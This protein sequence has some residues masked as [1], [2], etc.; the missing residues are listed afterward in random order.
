MTCLILLNQINWMKY[1]PRRGGVILLDVIGKRLGFGIDAPTG[2]ITDFGGSIKRR[3]HPCEGSLREFK[4]ESLGVFPIKISNPL[5]AL[6]PEMMIIF[7]P[8]AGDIEKCYKCFLEKL[9]TTQR[10]EVKDFIWI[11]LEDLEDVLTTGKYRES[12]MYEKVRSFLYPLLQEG[13]IEKLTCIFQE[14]I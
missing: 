3:E 8:F 4:E 2:E 9:K 5:V 14:T 13:L 6:S 11:P 12:I 1:I 10:I 7:L